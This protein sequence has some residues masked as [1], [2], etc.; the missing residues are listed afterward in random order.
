MIRLLCI[1]GSMNAGGAETFLM[2]VYRQLDRTKYQMDF[3]VAVKEKGFYDDEIRCLGGRIYYIT[4]KSEGVFKNFRDIKSLVKNEHY[5]HVLRTSQ[6]SLSALELFAAKLGGARLRVFRSSNSN[7]TTGTKKQLFI[8]KLFMDLPLL[9]ANVRIAPS[10]E[11]AEYMFGKGCITNG[12]A[13]LLHNGIDFD[14]YKFDFQKRCELRNKLGVGKSIVIGHIGRFNQQKNHVFLLEVF[15]EFLKLHDNSFL[16]LVGVGETQQKIRKLSEEMGIQ[17]K[18]LFL[19]IRDDIPDILS[20]MDIFVFPS[21]YEGMPNTVIE[22]QAADLPCLISENITKEAMLSDNI[23]YLSL[24]CGADEW[25]LEANKMIKTRNH[26]TLPKE[27]DIKEVVKSFIDIVYRT[28]D[29]LYV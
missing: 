20:A 7:T 9:F 27:Y 25:A 11:A 5:S 15:Y 14:Y 21:L 26:N 1:V 19:G 10:T 3:A 28:E 12:K 23:K 4:P 22:A 24:N 16:V 8:H 13:I 17:N 2:K 18:V 6:Q 29:D